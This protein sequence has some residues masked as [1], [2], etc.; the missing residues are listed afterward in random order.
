MNKTHIS[1]NFYINKNIC[2]YLNLVDILKMKKLNKNYYK[3]ISKYIII[4]LAKN[5]IEIKNLENK[6]FEETYKTFEFYFFKNILIFQNNF[7]HK[8]NQNFMNNIK[9]ITIIQK[10]IIKDIE[11]SKSYFLIKTEEKTYYDHFKKISSNFPYFQNNIKQEKMNILPKSKKYRI[12]KNLFYLTFQNKLFIKFFDD[13][14]EI[15]DSK[16]D[17]ELEIKPDLYQFKE[18][19]L[20]IVD[21]YLNE[22]YLLIKSEKNNLFLIMDVLKLKPI[23]VL[24]RKFIVFK[25]DFEE[26]IFDLKMSLNHLFMINKEGVLFEIKFL[27]KEFNRLL[28]KYS[29]SKLINYLVI[30]PKVC[31]IFK[32]QKIKKIYRKNN[33][34]LF[35][36]MNFYKK[37]EDYSKEDIIDFFTNINFKKFEKTVNYYNITGKKLIKMNSEK[38]KNFFGMNNFQISKLQDEIE[39]RKNKKINQPKL[40]AFGSNPTKHFCISNNLNHLVEIELPFFDVN[41]QIKDIIIGQYNILLLTNFNRIFCS[42]KRDKILKTKRKRTNSYYD[43]ENKKM[44]EK[45]K[46]TPRHKIV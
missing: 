34:F 30:K 13:S 27:K 41:E 42:M 43:E 32:K 31:K 5:K 21:F 38:L 33:F 29:T 40:Y 25:I 18:R 14:K 46:K 7:L 23:D 44:K 12:E 36:E 6:N 10:R 24:E 2:D 19:D 37:I 20:K 39:S 26:K 35:E 15:S 9:N 4:I 22:N 16:K 1:K 45:K 11:I 28:E 3:T 8:Q 17:F